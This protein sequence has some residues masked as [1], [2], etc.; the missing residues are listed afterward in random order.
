MTILVMGT[1]QLGAEEG[2]KAARLMAEHAA[3]VRQEEGCEEYAFAFDAA[4][5]TRPDPGRRA[6][7]VTGGTRRARKGGAPKDIWSCASGALAPSDEDR[8]LGRAILAQPDWRLRRF[9]RHKSWRRHEYRLLG[10]P[11]R[12]CHPPAL[13]CQ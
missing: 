5:L 11:E 9:C 12:R 1:I 8:R 6:L 3:R 10:D 13:S 2:A 7:E 4:D